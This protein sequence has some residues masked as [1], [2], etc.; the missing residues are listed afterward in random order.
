LAIASF[1][2]RAAQAQPA[3]VARIGFLGVGPATARADQAEAFKAGL[4]DLGCVEGRIIV[5]EERWA[6]FTDQ[7]NAFSGLARR[8]DPEKHPCI[9]DTRAEMKP[10]RPAGDWA[11]VQIADN[12]SPNLG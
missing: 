5:I 4:R 7:A 2:Q 6:D 8:S 11:S 10:P 1:R 3:K 9:V 12:G